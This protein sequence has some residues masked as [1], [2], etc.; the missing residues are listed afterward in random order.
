[1]Y[2]PLIATRL[3]KI[4]DSNDLADI[5]TKAFEMSL[6]G[7]EW[8][9]LVRP[10]KKGDP[11][12]TIVVATYYG[13]AIG[14]AVVIAKK[15][16]AIIERLAVKDQFRRKS[17]G[18]TLLFDVIERAQDQRL[19]SVSLVMPESFV[20]P[21]EGQLNVAIHWAKAVGLKPTTPFLKDYFTAYGTTEDGVKFTT[22]INYD[23]A[24]TKG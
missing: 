11:H 17:A 2:Q 1:M 5:D 13:N 21:V 9:E 8:Y 10:P 15:G 12:K 6:T 7:E 20:Y 23:N 19:K 22:P 4:D 24:S 14:F 3:A 18:R 16:E